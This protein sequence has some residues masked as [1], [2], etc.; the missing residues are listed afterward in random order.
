MNKNLEIGLKLGGGALLV[1]SVAALIYYLTRSAADK[2]LSAAK[3]YVGIRE[4]NNG[5]TFADKKFTE[6]LKKTGWSEGLPYCAAFVKMVI[7]SI[8]KGAAN[9]FLQ[10]QLSISSPQTYQNFAAMGK[11][12]YS[13]LI[14]KPEAGCIVC[15]AEH[16]EL[17]VDVDGDNMKVITAN[18]PIDGN[19]QG[20]GYKT[21]SISRPVHTVLGYVRIKKLN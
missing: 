10:K 3:K 7:S 14:P 17:C 20:V 21:R 15:Y 11:N 18:S 6:K 19:A 2:I 5:N 1:S 8:S 12:E 9:V 13:E 4:V 16:T